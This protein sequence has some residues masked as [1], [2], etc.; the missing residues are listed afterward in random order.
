MW[1]SKQIMMHQIIW[2]RE[3]ILMQLPE[4]LKHYEG[5]EG[6]LEESFDILAKAE[7]G[8]S[9]PMPDSAAEAVIDILLNTALVGQSVSLEDLFELM[10]NE[11]NKTIVSKAE[12]MTWNYNDLTKM[13]VESIY[14]TTHLVMPPAIE[15]PF[16]LK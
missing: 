7:C 5:Y 14:S 11:T 6:S 15:I 12:R 13:K 2:G 4:A 3:R 1:L 9:I 8:F 16:P 10:G